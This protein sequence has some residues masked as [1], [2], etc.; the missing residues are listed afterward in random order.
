MIEIE[1]QPGIVPCSLHVC[2]EPDSFEDGLLPGVT[3]AHLGRALQLGA[4]LSQRPSFAFGSQ[5][6]CFP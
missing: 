5:V 6:A 4:F 1:Y 2:T 3:R